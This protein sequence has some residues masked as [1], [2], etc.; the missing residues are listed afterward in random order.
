MKEQQ[1]RLL[2]T[3][4]HIGVVGGGLAG[5]SAA[6]SVVRSLND[7][8]DGGKDGP[9]GRRRGRITV[10]ERDGSV[11]DRREGYGMTLT[12]DPSGPLARLGVLEQA[13][14]RDCPSRC[15]YLFDEKGNVMGYYGNGFRKKE[16]GRGAGQRGNLRVPRGELRDV[17]MGALRE[18][19]RDLIVTVE[20]G[21]RLRSYVDRPMLER[22]DQLRASGSKKKVVREVVGSSKSEAALH[23]DGSNVPNG[24]SDTRRPVLLN[25]EDGTTDSVDLLVGA[26]EEVNSTVARQYLSTAP[27]GKKRKKSGDGETKPGSREEDDDETLSQVT[28]RRVGIFIVLGITDHLHPLIDERAYY[29]LDGTSRLFLMPFEGSRLDDLLAEDGNGG[30]TGE[31]VARRRTMWQLSFPADRDESSRLSGMSQG[32]LRDEVLRRCG[33][34]HEPFPGMVES[35]PLGT[36]WGTSLLDR[37]PRAFLDHR[38]RLEAH[39][40]V[41]CRVVLVVSFLLCALHFLF[42]P[43]LLF[44]LK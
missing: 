8:G 40:R 41:P 21:R 1:P 28:P 26:D 31:S 17:L 4:F 42:E 38:A 32:E 2:D 34:W 19:D 11:R 5:L 33:D 18:Q 43:C 30:C 35:T 24:L 16:D 29:T 9:R 37:D 6:L 44:L 14:R 15:H 25:F 27:F 13:A 36:V 39:G 3:D 12:Y 20:W 23:D 22:L 10:Y 7:D